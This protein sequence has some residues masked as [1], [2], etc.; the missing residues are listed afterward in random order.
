MFQVSRIKQRISCLNAGD[1]EVGSTEI[2]Q[3]REKRIII[4]ST[5]RSRRN[6]LSYD[7]KFRIGFLADPRR[8]N[9][10]VTR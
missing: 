10:A 6:Y 5:V 7:A 9:V 8:F 4:I 1:I 2:F 3:G